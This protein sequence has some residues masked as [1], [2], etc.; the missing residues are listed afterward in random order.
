V[1]TAIQRVGPLA[2]VA[3]IAATA[4]CK[5]WHPT[6]SFET[7]VRHRTA[8]DGFTAVHHVLALRT[9]CLL[10]TSQRCTF[11]TGHSNSYRL[12]GLPFG[13][14]VAGLLAVVSSTAG[15]TIV[16]LLARSAFGGS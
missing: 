14:L 15:A 1:L 11:D 2:I 4:I 6:P 13:T 7:F 10:S 16:F 5:E 12:G 9:Y 8:I 3:I